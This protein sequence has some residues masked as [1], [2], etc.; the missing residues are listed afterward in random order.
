MYVCS[1]Y[2]EHQEGGTGRA[3]LSPP[4]PSVISVSIRLSISNLTLVEE[5]DGLCALSPFTGGEK[6]LLAEH[7]HNTHMTCSSEKRSFIDA[8]PK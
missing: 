6:V 4:D 8:Y 1:S 5:I 3:E 7:M 2:I